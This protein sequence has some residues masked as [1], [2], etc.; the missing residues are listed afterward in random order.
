MGSPSTPEQHQTCPACGADAVGKFCSN[1]GASLA[2]AT[3]AACDAPLSPGAKFCHRCGS[4]AGAADPRSG[5]ARSFSSALPWGVA[6]IALVAVV[7]LVA[8]QRFGRTSSGAPSAVPDNA[9]EAMS[10]NAPNAPFAGATG[11]G[12]APDISN[13][14]P[15]EAAVRLY[16]RVMEAHEQG[17]ADTVQMFAPMAIT[18]YQMIG[19]LNLDDRYDMGRIAAVSGNEQLARAEADT[20]LAK[21][22]NHLLGLIL[23]ENAAHMR[24]DTAAERKYYDA[25][26]KAAPSE[27][28]KQLEEYVTHENDI[29]IA[30]DARRP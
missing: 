13:L 7:A 6:A 24:K 10:A 9:A 23:A 20:I 21:Y 29:T 2:G 5:D 3:C 12:A 11:N 15:A 18:A 14:S 17:K 27:R 1:C 19:N 4:P 28:G 8:G 25:L 30:L 22:P 16:N 26:Q